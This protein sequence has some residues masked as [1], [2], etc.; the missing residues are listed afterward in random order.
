MTNL[1]SSAV[2]E[3]VSYI[4]LPFY[5]V[6]RCALE[7]PKSD[8][9]LTIIAAAESDDPDTTAQFSQSQTLQS[10]AKAMQI[11]LL[12]QLAKKRKTVNG[13]THGS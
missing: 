3:G 7:F 8:H 1:W 5:S 13:A 12:E 2:G 10:T 9:L 6:V 11:T 4:P